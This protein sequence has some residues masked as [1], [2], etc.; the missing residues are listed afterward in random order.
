MTSVRVWLLRLKD[1]L[2]PSRSDTEL[3]RE[4]RA[5]LDLAAE[6]ARSPEGSAGDRTATI[7]FGGVAQAMES[8]RDQ[9]G[10]P[11]LENLARD[12]KYG[13]RSLRRNPT[14]T[15]VTAVTLALGIGA[16]TTIATVVNAILLAPL[17]Y[18]D[19]DRLVR[20]VENVPTTAGRS[21]VQVGPTLAEFREW[22]RR[23]TTLSDALALQGPAQRT[24]H[25]GQSTVRLWRGS[26]SANGFSMLGV[27]PILGRIFS[28]ADAAN[29]N[30]AVISYEVWQ[31]VF[32]NDVNVIGRTFEL[33][34]PDTMFQGPGSGRSILTVVGVLPAGFSLPLVRAMDFITPAVD[35]PTRSPGVAMIGR[36]Q[37]GLS[38]T[39]ATEEANRLGSAV[40]PPQPA[41]ARRLTVTRFEVQNVK[42]QIV[43]PLRPALRV[44]FGS[45]AVLLLIVCANVANLLLARGT[46][47]Q[48]EMAARIAIGAS[49]GRVVRQVLSEC[50]LLATLGGFLGAGFAAAGITAV[51]ALA[52]L[53]SPGI[54]RI[55]WGDSI[56]PRGTEVGI[57]VKV[58]AIALSI[59]AVTSIAFGV[60]PA[61]FLART[62]PQALTTRT[63][64]AS[65]L[66]IRVRNG[67]AVAQVVMATILLVAAGLLIHSF[68]N[69]RNVENGF[70][71]RH[72]VV[73]QL[74][75]PGEYSLTRKADAI[76]RTLARLRSN[77]DI[78]AAGFTRAGILLPET[79]GIGVFV[80]PSQTL[81]DMRASPFRPSLRPVSAG[82]LTAM[83]VPLLEGR[84]L[85]S[86]DAASAPP[87][88]VISRSV[89][90][91]WFGGA[92]AVGQTVEWHVDDKAAV[93]IPIV[94]PMRIVGVVEDIHNESPD[95]SAAPDV[96][97]D[98][99]QA[100]TFA[101]RW[102]WPIPRRDQL[103]FGFVSMAV[104]TRGE[105][106]I[107]AP[108]VSTIVHDVDAN[109]GVDA[110]IPMT[111]LAASSI[112]RQRFYAS[113]VSMFAAVAAMLAAIGVYGVLAY[114]VIQRTNE[115]GIRTALGAARE[116]ILGLV[117]KK[118][119][120][121]GAAGVSA[122]LV[123]AAG[124]AR[125]LEGLLFG[126]SPLDTQTFVAV[127]LLF[128]VVAALAS[129]LPARRA[130]KV[131]PL[132]ALRHE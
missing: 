92:G 50:L 90:R 131:D 107:A 75:F 108:A 35:N 54:F 78:V 103:A 33:E 98:Y 121:V 116:R 94:V 59:A 31:R 42:D 38:I 7:Q 100:L 80:P 14:F 127:A 67:L 115:I 26:I 71:P 118:G 109:V 111:R 47:R 27:R 82:Y 126:T 124:S 3:E 40:R 11:W 87:V 53:D 16:A 81:A 129:Y 49:R 39:A 95:R 23:S 104:R 69:I 29:P 117:L 36:L 60:L 12:V 2:W 120:L 128:G 85:Q 41:G 10:L 79:I 119:L 77:G 18:A 132:V 73:F 61:L 83:G 4:L 96:F 72:V 68:A 20:I 46:A 22:R 105:P 17:P 52:S 34:A 113:T 64:T 110:M 70:D 76:E 45:V 1:T 44:L 114:D 43:A 97:V 101:E 123:I 84:E 125:L 51:K 89:A 19:S 57:D 32:Q 8:L 74:V 122:G 24:I 56:L 88:A 99:R 30:A 93:P 106:T 130:T 112:A 28:D 13:I 58:F 48:R 9:R 91:Q 65:R 5:H 15:V 55:V 66:H 21:T 86:T 6:A 102:G 25:I 63:S 37:V 62:S